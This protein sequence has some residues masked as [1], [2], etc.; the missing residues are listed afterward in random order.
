[1]NATEMSKN[2]DCVWEIKVISRGSKKKTSTF[3]QFHI[4]LYSHF[5][6]LVK[7]NPQSN[8]I[9]NKNWKKELNFA[10]SWQY[11]SRQKGDQEDFAQCYI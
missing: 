2:C 10:H 4:P 11:K 1:M 3:I 5:F 9:R 8:K 7:I 6:M